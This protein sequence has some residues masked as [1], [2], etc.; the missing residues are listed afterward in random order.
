M[1]KKKYDWAF[2]MQP[3]G[4]IPRA[5][6]RISRTEGVMFDAEYDEEKDRVKMM[7]QFDTRHIVFYLEGTEI[8]DFYNFTKD[9]YNETK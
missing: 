8:E 6:G 7:L 4:Q 3:R 2:Q 1:A 9:V 5:H